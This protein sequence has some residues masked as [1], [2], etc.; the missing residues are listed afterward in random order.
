MGY[1]S[2]MPALQKQLASI[3][4]TLGAAAA[5]VLAAVF[6][7]D[8]LG[9]GAPGLGPLQWLMLLAAATMLF[10]SLG[11]GK[12]SGRLLLAV[13]TT[14]LMTIMSGAVL[15][16]SGTDLP[17]L[18]WNLRQ[19]VIG[20][21]SLG[22]YQADPQLGWRHIPE[23]V[24]DARH[25]DF[26]ATYTIASDGNRP[27]GSVA[28]SDRQ[29]W[30]LGGSFTFG[31]GVDDQETFASILAQRE[32]QDFEV[33]NAG[34]N[35]WGSGQCLIR[36]QELLSATPTPPRL[37][38]YTWISHHAHRNADRLHGVANGRSRPLFV[39]D[40]QGP[41]FDRLISATQGVPDSQQL[42]EREE[43]I[44]VA[45]IRAMDERCR[46]R[47]VAFVCVVLKS[48]Y[49]DQIRLND[50]LI[51]ALREADVRVL[52]LRQIAM[53]V[54]PHDGHPTPRGHAAIAEAIAD[55]ELLSELLGRDE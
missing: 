18:F 16:V 19:S 2:E 40:E 20:T 22:I 31:H 30:F 33:L 21:P 47:E 26:R 42:R 13:S 45:L 48:G 4:W 3:R 53:P 54:Y 50:A 14:V 38:V 44:A 27:T 41:R 15:L 49:D 11:L 29:V 12:I 9:F 1:G 8:W 46:L 7:P 51:A 37:V 39:L 23:T 17:F 10:V 6:L 35:G 28:A 5:S 25:L 34:V 32:W 52:D 55:D 24:A 36:L 43:K